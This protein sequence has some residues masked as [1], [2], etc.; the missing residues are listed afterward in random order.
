[1][2]EDLPYWLALNEFH[3]FGPQAFARLAAH[4]PNMKT[5]FYAPAQELVKAG[6]PT[7]IAT[8]FT[9]LR[10]NIIPES[11]IPILEKN[12][13][14]TIRIID[15]AYPTLL[16]EINDPPPVIYYTGT[17]PDPNAVHT[18]VVG[19][20]K[21]TPYGKQVTEELTTDL[22]KA[23]LVITSGLAYG[24]DEIAHRSTV[25]AGGITLAVLAGGLHSPT[26]RGRHLANKIIESGGAVMSEF[27]LK[28]PSLKHFFPYRNRIISGLAK[29][30]LVIEAAE[31]SGTLI[32]ARCA[33]EQNRDVF[34]VPGPITSKTSAGTNN[35]IKLGATPTTSAED[36]LNALNIKPDKK[37]KIYKPDSKE[38]AVILTILSK[39]P[40]HIDEI[41]RQTQI[42][43]ARIAG[44]L[45]LMEMKGRT[46]HIGGMYYILT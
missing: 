44:S 29:A 30:L 32:T 2:Q 17:F 28:T 42:D 46:K 37:P 33:L 39:S 35:L 3:K 36:V 22:A 15:D 9:H 20:R 43:S 1:M 7:S 25:N 45:S 23:G 11:I 14:K 10:E 5:A 27:P 19:S 24:I 12:N 6:I 18:S 16:R 40:I 41:I 38:E 8:S 13:I 34:A 26:T 4:F 31:S 21:C